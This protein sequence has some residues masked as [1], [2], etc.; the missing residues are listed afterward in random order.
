MSKAF[1]AI[2][3]GSES[4]LAVM[5]FAEKTLTELG[6]ASEINI[7]SAHRTPDLTQRYVADACQRGAEVFIAAAGMAAH[8]AGTVA[9]HTIRGPHRLGV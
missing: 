1:V 3:M 7:L 4:D 8:L 9:A 5:R 6:V 2:L